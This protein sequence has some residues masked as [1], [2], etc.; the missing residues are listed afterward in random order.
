MFSHPK[1]GIIGY[2][3]TCFCICLAHTQMEWKGFLN[4]HCSGCGVLRNLVH[5]WGTWHISR[6]GWYLIWY[7][8]DLPPLVQYGCYLY[9]FFLLM[10][11]FFWLLIWNTNHLSDALR[12]FF[13]NWCC[14][15][16]QKWSWARAQRSTTPDR[17]CEEGTNYHAI[18]R[19]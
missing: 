16:L 9:H 13:P 19:Q 3:V 10:K 18:S 6:E 7:P 15:T 14:W 12:M 11:S 5:W 1:Y 8:T 2:T 17:D 4:R